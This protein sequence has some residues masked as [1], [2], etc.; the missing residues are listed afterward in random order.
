MEKI[1]FTDKLAGRVYSRYIKQVQHTVKSLPQEDRTDVLM[2]INSHIYEG[3][4]RS[5]EGSEMD[6]LLDVLDK[7]GEPEVVLKPLVA[8]KALE[9]A[10]KT[11]NPV[12]VF[13]ALAL[14]IGNGISYIMIACLYLILL[15]FGFL[16]IMKLAYPSQVGAFYSDSGEFIVLGMPASTEG[17]K[18][19]LGHFFI[20]V[21]LLCI[22]V[23]YLVIT[24]I[25]KLRRT[26]INR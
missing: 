1:E 18:E 16:I 5:T 6:C 17:L 19:A 2:E 23:S 13:K 4:Q 25:L 21:M 12:H 9:Q 22:V 8:E 24:Y 26:F 7:L 3:M 11:F 15:G 14:N 10:T 20:P